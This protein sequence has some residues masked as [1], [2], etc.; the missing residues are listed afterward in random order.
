VKIFA[1][2]EAFRKSAEAMEFAETWI[3]EQKTGDVTGEKHMNLLA[4][5]KVCPH[6]A[7][8][9]ILTLLDKAQDDDEVLEQIAMGPVQFIVEWP[10]DD[11]VPVLQEAIRRHPLFELCTRGKRQ[12]SDSLRWR[13]LGCNK[14]FEA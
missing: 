4:W 13:Q 2:I 11:L 6:Q 12:H 8:G 9:I 10:N 1:D 14:P 3:Q 5:Q 7:L